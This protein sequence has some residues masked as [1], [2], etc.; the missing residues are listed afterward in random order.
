MQVA[1]KTNPLLL[2]INELEQWLSETEEKDIPELESLLS[3]ARDT[4]NYTVDKTVT[5]KISFRLDWL[6][7]HQVLAN[8]RVGDR[9]SWK[10]EFGTYKG[11]QVTTGLPDAWVQIDGH[12][13]RSFNPL[14][15]DLV[16]DFDKPQKKISFRPF[17]IVTAG[18]AYGE[19]KNIRDGKIEVRL[20]PTGTYLTCGAEDITLFRRI[21]VGDY[22]QSGVNILEVTEVTDE[23]MCVNRLT[24]SEGHLYPINSQAYNFESSW[25]II[26]TFTQA[27]PHWRYRRG[28]HPTGFPSSLD[29]FQDEYID[30]YSLPFIDQLDL[31]EERLLLQNEH[32]EAVSKSG[33]KGKEKAIKDIQKVIQEEESYAQLLR[34]I[35]AYETI[36]NSS[37][38]LMRQVLEMASR[39]LVTETELAMKLDMSPFELQK[40]VLNP[41]VESKMLRKEGTLGYAINPIGRKFIGMSANPDLTEHDVSN[42]DN[43]G[44]QDDLDAPSDLTMTSVSDND[45]E[46][47][48]S[49]LR[50]LLDAETSEQKL[51]VPTP[52]IQEICG[53]HNWISLCAGQSLSSGYYEPSW[54]EVVAD[55]PLPTPLLPAFQPEAVEKEIASQ[56]KNQEA[57]D[58]ESPTFMSREEAEK[59]ISRANSNCNRLTLIEKVKVKKINLVRRTLAEIDQGKG[60]EALGFQNM[61]KFLKSG[62]INYPYSSLQKQWQAAR[63]ENCLGLEIGTTPEE[64]CRKLLPLAHDPAKMQEAYVM[65]IDL[66]GDKKLTA[67]LIA[68]CVEDVMGC[69]PKRHQKSKCQWVS[70]PNAT[71]HYRVRVLGTEVNM[72]DSYTNTIKDL[73]SVS[74]SSNEAPENLIVNGLLGALSEALGTSPQGAIAAAVSFLKNQNQAVAA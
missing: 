69:P 66:A 19:V 6:L 49:D 29:S 33:K 17:D 70:G 7:R 12:P 50:K 40:H 65:A 31:S 2:T 63:V 36:K 20:I 43:H 73:E 56:P 52:L 47:D 62:L 68:Q 54:C 57:S 44:E 35:I 28:L 13:T 25:E 4:K 27:C 60:Y 1:N 8:L 64:Q 37:S 51:L 9:V 26:E 42:V 16:P 10:S 48:E 41:L 58:E 23:G 61:T 3:K 11:P 38:D 5:K 21:K 55:S 15:L 74:Q 24:G 22:L 14:E 39:C 32:L 53:E 67:K 45:L 30:C 34:K 59:L 71:R 72:H 46:V 18:N